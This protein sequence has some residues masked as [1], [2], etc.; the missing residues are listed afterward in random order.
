LARISQ[1]QVLSAP[2]TLEGVLPAGVDD[3]ERE[4]RLLV[5]K[6]PLLSSAF[7]TALASDRALLSTWAFW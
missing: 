4:A 7:A 3:G 5:V 1:Y 6:K 2:G